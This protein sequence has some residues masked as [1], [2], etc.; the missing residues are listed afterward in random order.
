MRIIITIILFTFSLFSFK[1]VKAQ[2][3]EL[4]QLMLDLEKLNQ[5]RAILT[6]MYKGYQI[7]T[8]GYN[9]IK[10]LAEGNFNLHKVFL[11]GLLQVSPTV[12]K[13]KRVADI[14]SLQLVL[15]KEYKGAF[16]Q[17][18]SANI[19]NADDLQYLQD[20]YQNLLDR[21]LKNLDELLMI[22]TSGQL[23]MNDAERLNAIDRIYTDMQ[24]K[25]QFLR[26]FNDKTY[27]VIVQK[28]KG[29]QDVDDLSRLFGIKQ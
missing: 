25:L 27:L 1:P 8:K 10:N 2:S 23:R 9:N 16:R 21:S 24:D 7:L 20:V 14:I 29:L 3:E 11:D 26:Y 19:L 13:Y 15:V 5:F 22:I 18:S 12:T 17:F 28:K 4:Q 6:N